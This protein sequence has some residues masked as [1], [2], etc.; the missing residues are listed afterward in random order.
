MAGI[1]PSLFGPT[2][3]ELEAQ[4]KQQQSDL[5][6]AYAAQGPRA[7][8][9]A[10]IGTLIGQGLTAL[11]GNQ[12]PEIKKATN[13]YK[14]LQTTQQELGADVS[15]PTKLY[16]ALQQRFTEAG[17]P[18]IAAKVAEEGSS[19]ILDWNTKQATIK[20]KEFDLQQDQDA[21]NALQ[22][23]IKDKALT[24]EKPT[25][26]EIISTISQYVPADKLVPLLQ[27]SAD[28]E[29][30]RNVLKGQIDQQH[31]DRIFRIEQMAD[32]KE[33]DRAFE[34]EKL[35]Y[36][37]ETKQLIA[38]LKQDKPITGREARYLDNVAVAGNEAI[39][40]INNII[41]LPKTV[42]GGFWGSGLPKMQSGK[43]LFE[44][45]IGS[46]K[47][48]MTPEVVQRYNTE[49]KNI[50]K[51]FSTLRNGGLA[52]TNDDVNAF[53]EQFRINE[54]D[55][56]LTALTKLAQMRQTFERVAEIKVNSANTPKEQQELWKDWLGQVKVA[57]P[58]TVNDINS[59]A[60]AKD[61]T[62]TFA[63]FLA[64]TKAKSDSLQGNIPQG[65]IDKLKSNPSLAADFDAKFG[66]GA[67]K[68]YLG[69]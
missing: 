37:R 29:A 25:Q 10:G 51:Y 46:L 22:K 5:I 53:E 69:N 65:A 20:Q 47:N 9:G 16:P 27:T 28:K 31:E 59:I 63:S 43:G 52:S 6:K 55:K 7:A 41:N 38:S 62:Q 68:K 15:D 30:Y 57:I 49:I 56:P 60:N 35:R 40:G 3:Q 36:E 18:D 17:F 44:A 11:F 45:P 67:S 12:D 23:L 64:E 19:K 34:K 61:K 24:G 14:V 4:R 58:I 48:S 33:K 21:K 13:V 66:T 50:G 1:V 26:E 2:P 42:T 32:Q 39:A 8:A 54:N